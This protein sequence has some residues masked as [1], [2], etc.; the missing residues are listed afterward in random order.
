MTQWL[1]NALFGSMF[2]LTIARFWVLGR[3]AHAVRVEQKDLP[4]W[5]FYL[6]GNPPNATYD[7]MN[8]PGEKV[9]KRQKAFSIVTVLVVFV[10]YHL[11]MVSVGSS[12]TELLALE[13][14][15]TLFIILAFVI[16]IFLIDRYVRGL[17]R[18]NNVP[19]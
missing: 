2:G 5:L 4:A 15:F 8:P 13:P 10:F 6:A 9:G 1:F 17:P 14:G 12:A 3:V 19:D 11:A 7:K 18:K 16:P